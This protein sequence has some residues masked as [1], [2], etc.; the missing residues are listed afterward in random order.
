MRAIGMALTLTAMLAACQGPQPPVPVL[1]DVSTLT[2]RWE[3]EYG[4]RESGRTGSILFTL[5]AGTDTAHGDVLMVPKQAEL[6]PAPRPG[7]PDA[8]D[9]RRDRPAQPLPIAFVRAADGV[10]EGRLAPYRDPDCGC[11]LTTLFVGRLVAPDRIEGTFVSIHGEAGRE[12]QGWW[13]VERRPRAGQPG[14]G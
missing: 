6:P 2:G 4:S 10:V 3:G 7:D 12:V 8:M 11:L 13:R 9:F 14:P 5:E 1:G